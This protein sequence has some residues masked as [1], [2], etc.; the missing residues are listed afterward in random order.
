MAKLPLP[1]VVSKLAPDVKRY[2]DRIRE[3]FNGGN[4]VIVQSDLTDSG[5]HAVNADG[6][7]TALTAIPDCPS[8]PAPTNFTATGAMTVIVL[9][10]DGTQYGAGGCHQFTQIFRAT[11]DTFSAAQLIAVSN[12]ELYSDAVGP[13]T[14]YYYW[15]RFVNANGVIGP[16]HGTQ[17]VYGATGRD[18]GYLLNVLAEA[19]GNVSTAP[20]FQI[21]QPTAIAGVKVFAGTYITSAFIY[22]GQITN[23]KIG[24]AAVDSAKIADASIVSAKIADGEVTNAKIGDKIQSADG[25]TWEI[26][27]TGGIKARNIQIQDKAGNILF[28]VTNGV[29][30]RLDSAYVAGLGNFAALNTVTA[31]NI[32][33][34]IEAGAITDAYIGDIIQS[35]NYSETNGK[36]VSGWKIDKQGQMQMAAATFRGTLDIVNADTS[37][38][39]V[40][41]TNDGLQVIVNGVTRV[42]I[43]KL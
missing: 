42:K 19:S 31:A 35:A 10:W 3:A 40:Q 26:D 25:I 34:Y 21:D 14:A 15:I 7:L 12:G 5:S 23:A 17:G 16:L 8:P 24:T 37:A 20:F 33:T 18:I 4:P 1:T 30:N 22:E 39:V 38:G 6:T 36:A 11:T 2:L 41:V 29:I 13:D 28:G 43:G 32:S 9:E 27:K